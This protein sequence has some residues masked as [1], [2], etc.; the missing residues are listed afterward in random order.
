MF[1]TATTSTNTFELAT[2]RITTRVYITLLALSMGVIAMYASIDLRAQ[3]ITVQNPSETTF[4]KLYK[5]YRSTLH[6]PCSEI[7]IPYGSF[8]ST[9]PVFH[10][11]CTSWLV[12][13]EWITY[14]T[15]IQKEINYLNDDFRSN[16][17]SFFTAL[18]S[19]CELANVTINNAWRVV[20]HSVLYADEALPL[21]YFLV[22]ARSIFSQF[23]S[24]TAEEL[25][26]SFAT[27]NLL[28][29]SILI[30][31]GGSVT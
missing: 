6:C 19:L 4:N 14:L 26:N 25:K 15:D 11:V 7:T 3:S 8:M 27:I 9:L 30:T 17:P 18:A 12:S 22:H 23:Q 10:P 1:E 2:G 28:T 31:E 16:A 24:T 21:N 20:S 5:T 13:Q 29:R